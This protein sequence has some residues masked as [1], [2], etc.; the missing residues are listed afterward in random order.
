MIDRS[1]QSST[2]AKS[3]S[4]AKGGSTK[5][6]AAA[7][8]PPTPAP[9]SGAPPPTAPGAGGPAATAGAT[10]AAALPSAETTQADLQRLKD[11]EVERRRT[12]PLTDLHLWTFWRKNPLGDGGA[13]PIDDPAW[14]GPL[15]EVQIAVCSTSGVFRSCVGSMAISLCRGF[16]GWVCVRLLVGVCVETES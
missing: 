9:A 14:P 7:T 10:A 2:K 5:K 13:L 12:D 6:P 16:R 3:S 4:K 1:Q 8:A 15:K 11:D